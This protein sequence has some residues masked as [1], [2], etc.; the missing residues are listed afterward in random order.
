LDGRFRLRGVP[1]L[2]RWAL[3]PS[4][5]VFL[6]FN[7][8]VTTKNNYVLSQYYQNFGEKSGQFALGGPFLSKKRLTLHIS[9]T[10]IQNKLQIW[11]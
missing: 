4:L 6:A 2:F 11:N 5:E 3:L 9:V 8:F 10:N 1:L 7:F